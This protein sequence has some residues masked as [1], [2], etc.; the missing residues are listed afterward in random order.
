[1]RKERSITVS[2]HVLAMMAAS[3][4]MSSLANLS[5]RTRGLA[6]IRA[7]K[8][9][10]DSLND[11][12]ALASFA[13]RLSALHN[14][15]LSG[16]RQFLL[17]GDHERMSSYKQDLIRAWQAERSVAAD[18][19]RFSLSP[20]TGTTRAAWLTST[21]VHFCA[22]AY[23]TVP[24][25]HPD[26]A[27][28][29]VLGNFLKNG[30]LH[31]AIREQGGAYGGGASHDSSNAVFRFYSY[32]DPRIEGT[33]RDFDHSIEWMLSTQHKPAALE[34]AILGV[35]SAVDKPGSPAGDAKHAFHNLLQGRLPEQ[36][37]AFRRRL[38]QVSIDDLKRVCRHYLRPESASVAV[39]TSSASRAEVEALGLN[40]QSV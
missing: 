28:L 38:L 21:Q 40:V 19:S 37:L 23:K 22:K 15:V 18:L 34:E 7:T 25:E 32:R 16:A 8:A 35:I 4:E 9:L 5:H 24:V 2:G 17:V 29:A 33:L 20:V 10:D 31:R 30:F 3:C 1:M 14:K 27:P 13:Q 36:R 12:G 26:A 11:R 39:V 6:G